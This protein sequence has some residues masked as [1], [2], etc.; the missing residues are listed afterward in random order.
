[1]PLIVLSA[2]IF[3]ASNCTLTNSV[4]QIDHV[5][6]VKEYEVNMVDECFELLSLVWRLAERSEYSKSETEYQ[7][8]LVI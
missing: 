8:E 7:K 2:V 3:S 5:D 6:G 4:E 1:M